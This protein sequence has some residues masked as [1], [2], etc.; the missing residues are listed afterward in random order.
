MSITKN[1]RGVI[2]SH[3]TATHGSKAISIVHKPTD[4]DLPIAYIGDKVKCPGNP[5]NAKGVMKLW[6]ETPLGPL[7]AYL[8]R[9]KGTKHLA[10]S[11]LFPLCEE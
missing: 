8:W 2:R 1:G 7:R 3:D 5:P 10:G 4:M 9:L 11:R 6:R